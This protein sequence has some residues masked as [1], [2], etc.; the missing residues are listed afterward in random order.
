MHKSKKKMNVH[1]VVLGIDNYYTWKQ[2]RKRKQFYLLWAMNDNQN[3]KP[4][5]GTF[6]L[7]SNWKVPSPAAGAKAES[8]SC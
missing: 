6:P 5:V 1:K 4:S 8:S 3:W 7:G 2:I